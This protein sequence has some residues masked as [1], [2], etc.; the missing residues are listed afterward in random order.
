[1]S[2]LLW[3]FPIKALKKAS[4]EH[5]R[6]RFQSVRRY[7]CVHKNSHN[8]K[9]VFFSFD[10]Y[11]SNANCNMQIHKKNQQ[12]NNCKFHN[13]STDA[14]FT[15][16]K[17]NAKPTNANFTIAVTKRTFL[18]QSCVVRLLQRHRGMGI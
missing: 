8:R 3:L 6:N 11:L 13:K 9:I 10:L 12:I 5:K 14:N 2:P 17:T 4:C 7:A 1:M 18:S 16:A 15:N